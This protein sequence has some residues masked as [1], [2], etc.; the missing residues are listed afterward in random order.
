MKNGLASLSQLVFHCQPLHTIWYW[1]TLWKPFSRHFASNCY[2][3]LSC[4]YF[5]EQ[6]LTKSTYIDDSKEQLGSTRALV[7]IEYSVLS[8]PFFT[9][10]LHPS[11]NFCYGKSSCYVV[12]VN[13]IPIFDGVTTITTK[14]TGK[15]TPQNC[16]N[17]RYNRP[18]LSSIYH[19]FQ[20]WHAEE[21]LAEKYDVP[22]AVVQF[23]FEILE[24]LY[25]RVLEDFKCSDSSA[26]AMSF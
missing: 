16:I 24:F 14:Y 20:T 10:F 13:P 2:I 1:L 19:I 12:L 4:L 6:P 7:N 26:V 5:G 9:H 8:D 17:H 25:S 11:P 23:E 18:L 21:N 15:I 3:V 22:T